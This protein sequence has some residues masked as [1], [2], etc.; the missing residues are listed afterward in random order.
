[1]PPA[2]P[3]PFLCG[4]RPLQ[5]EPA[6]GPFPARAAGLSEKAG[7]V[8]LQPFPAWGGGCIRAEGVP[9]ALPSPAWWLGLEPLPRWCVR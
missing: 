1:M 9:A 7:K 5:C 8:G 2:L 3:A 6:G 4:G